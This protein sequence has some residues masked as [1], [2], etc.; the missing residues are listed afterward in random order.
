MANPTGSLND[1]LLANRQKTWNGLG[2]LLFWGTIYAVILALITAL[3][4][5]FG[6]SWS[7]GVPSAIAVV[8]G[9]IVVVY[10]ASRS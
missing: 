7:L 10:G 8:V 2:R 6:P 9:F 5:V 3:H 4:A 1:Q